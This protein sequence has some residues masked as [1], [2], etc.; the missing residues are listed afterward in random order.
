MIT[1]KKNREAVKN[2]IA[3]NVQAFAEGK[4]QEKIAEAVAECR[5]EVRVTTPMNVD[6]DALIAYVAEYGYSATIVGY[7]VLI[8]W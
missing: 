5:F 2:N 1:A 8:K 3:E 6:D 4:L 7:E